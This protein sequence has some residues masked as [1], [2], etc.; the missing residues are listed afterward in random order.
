MGSEHW[1]KR[2]GFILAAIGSAIGLGNVWRFSWLCYKNGGGAFL[3]PY[4]IALLVIGLPLIILEFSLGNYFSGSSPYIFKKIRGQF[5]IIGWFAVINVLIIGTYYAV[6]L[7]W[8]MDYIGLSLL[9]TFVSSDP[10]GLFTSL[11]NTPLLVIVGL[12]ITWAT[13]WY[14]L[15]HGVSGGIEKACTV[16]I[17][18]LW[19]LSVILV[20][21]GVTLPGADTGINWYLS[22]NWSALTHGSVWIDAFGQTLF[23]LS[24][25]AGPLIVY[26]SYL[27]KNSE[28][29]NSA[30]IITFANSG[31][32]F[33]FGFATWG[34]I[35]YLMTI[36][37]VSNPSN[38]NVPLNGEGLAFVTI[39]TAVSSLPGGDLMAIAFG[40]VFFITLWL[41]GYTSLMSNIE[42]MY[43]ALKDKFN[44]P[45]KKTVTILTIFSLIIGI[46]FAFSPDS[47]SAV[48]FAAGTINLI[49][50]VLVEAIIAS[51]YFGLEKLRVYANENA[52]F[53]L[54]KWFDYLLMFAV[55]II[56]AT[57][58]GYGLMSAGYIMPL[59]FIV[60]I[61]TII[62]TLFLAGANGTSVMWTENNGGDA[63]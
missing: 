27:P 59:S 8:V 52:E 40:S 33:F 29:P 49:W 62:A 16:A 35:G 34:I 23:T 22:P 20:I 30:W 21:R 32:S 36:N 3:I 14:T 24:L 46:L 15:Y 13:V 37:N 47:I 41:A 4:F 54:G 63:K 51:Y 17:P 28:L 10:S 2:R 6:I 43:S 7:A 5:E 55:P 39:P 56:L 38:L 58:L 48:D 9:N 25:M 50:V 45:R 57:I 18:T 61:A 31:F 44:A 60:L 53:E 1:K 26:A 42:P 19:I 12:I 11:I